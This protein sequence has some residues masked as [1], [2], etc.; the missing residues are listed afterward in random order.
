MFLSAVFLAL[1]ALLGL[2]LTIV[3][4]QVAGRANIKHPQSTH[5]IAAVLIVPFAVAT[6]YTIC[7]LVG[8]LRRRNWAR[9]GGVVL[10]VGLALFAVLLLLM[11]TALFV[12]PKLQHKATLRPSLLVAE[13][14]YLIATALGIWLAIYLNTRSVKHV[15]QTPDS[16]SGASTCFPAGA[17][18]G[19]SLA[20][21]V[22]LILCIIGTVTCIYLLT[23]A[24]SGKPYFYLG[25]LMQGKTANNFRVCVGT[26]II[27]LNIGIFLRNISA[28]YATL[29]I[30]ISNIASL[31]L[32]FVPAYRARSM[33]AFVAHASS[34]N[35]TALAHNIRLASMGLSCVASVLFV[36]ALWTDLAHIRRLHSDQ[37]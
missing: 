10:G 18:Q 13:L 29:L 19:P 8:L 11:T 20:R 30:Q 26:V 33:E 25:I 35:S 5:L 32:L 14:S 17:G 1:I 4:V 2:F 9:L 34:A 24:Y 28:Y 12:I 37:P 6:L 7:I 36:W 3:L 22:V 16:S 31:L 23:H 21:I 27:A 15:F